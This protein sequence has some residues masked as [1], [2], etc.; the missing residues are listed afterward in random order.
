MSCEGVVWEQG[1]VKAQTSTDHTQQE[2]TTEIPKGSLT[3][4]GIT[5]AITT[6]LATGYF[7]NLAPTS[8]PPWF[9]AL[10]LITL[11]VASIGTALGW[12]VVRKIVLSRLGRV[13]KGQVLALAVLIPLVAAL[14]FFTLEYA[15]PEPL[16]P[17]ELAPTAEASAIANNQED[18]Y[19][20]TYSYEADKA[21]DGED[22]TA[23]R[24]GGNGN[25]QW[26]EL[27]YTRPVR[28]SEIAVIP[29]HDKTD[30]IYDRFHQLYVVREALIKFSG[31]DRKYGPGDVRELASFNYDRTS[32]P[33]GLPKPVD[34]RK[35]R[36][37]VKDTYPPCPKH[38]PPRCP[39]PPQYPPFH[40]TAISEIVVN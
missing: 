5:V 20:Q 22:D 10:Y 37:V 40:A 25:G 19:E 36:I 32:Q 29:G 15:G 1:I 33:V 9:T 28:V 3:V 34:T 2:T 16:S 14:V 35:V 17:S 39:E 7:A 24:V 11:S 38:G 30:G 13:F 21:I 18:T 4:F 8:Y 12:L 27:T 31:T 23:W 6:V 26:I